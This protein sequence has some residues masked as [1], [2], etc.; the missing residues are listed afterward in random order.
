MK[1]FNLLLIILVALGASALTYMATSARYT[2][3]IEVTD[4][5]LQECESICEENDLYWG[6]TLCEGDTWSDFQEVRAE[7]HLT[8]F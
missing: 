3:Y 8:Q 7:L 1:K 6:D 4:N 5:L 2:K